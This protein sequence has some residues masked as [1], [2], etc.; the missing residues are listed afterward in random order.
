VRSDDGAGGWALEEAHE[1]LSGG[2][3]LARVQEQGALADGGV[4]VC[5]HDPARALCEAT[6]GIDLEQP[7]KP[8]GRFPL[9]N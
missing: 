4:Q 3:V 9:A 6:F 5:G 2:L 1:G 8:K 7:K